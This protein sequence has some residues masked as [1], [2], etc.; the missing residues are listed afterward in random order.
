[1]VKQANLPKEAYAAIELLRKHVYFASGLIFISEHVG[2]RPG[3]L[4]TFLGN[5]GAGKSTLVRTL[6]IDLLEASK[7]TDKIF[8][9]LSEET[10]HEFLSQLHRS[11]YDQN[12]DR[13]YVLSEIDFFTEKMTKK[14][15]KEK[16]IEG[17]TECGASIM[18]FDNITTSQLYFDLPPEGQSR[19][20]LGLS[21]L[22]KD[23]NIPIIIIAHT[24]GKI[25]ENH[26]RIID[27]NE[28]R[29]NKT[30]VNL[31]HFFYIMQRFDLGEGHYYQT[32]RITK[33]RGQDV[34]HRLFGMRYH[35]ERSIYY[36]FKKLKFT[37]FRE[38]YK[39]RV[40]L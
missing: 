15:V 13:L 23:K 35:R 10:V 1:M 33:H 20:A 18:I 14:Q 16:L 21:K 37:D 9:Y 17:I 25:T 2:Y 19:T 4:H 8:V 24:E 5:S 36:D 11:G 27:Q 3:C 39:K 12:L 6:V 26:P 38:A 32:I 28:I 22:A 31:S 7:P 40:T 34:E 30:I 29:G